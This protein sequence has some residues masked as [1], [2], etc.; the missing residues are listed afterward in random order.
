MDG[1]RLVGQT[2]EDRAVAYLR[3]R[4]YAI[5]ARNWR[6]ALGELDIVARLGDEIVIVEVRTLTGPGFGTPE[7][8][9][10]PGKRRRLIRA[11]T[12]YIRQIKHQGDWRIDVIAIDG[13]GLRHLRDAVSLW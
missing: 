2:G 9:V 3:R 6:H 8:S 5:L 7:A 10:G 4:G 12:A 1:R 13:G 11:A